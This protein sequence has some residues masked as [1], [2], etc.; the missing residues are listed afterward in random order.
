[1]LALA[2]IK[3]EFISSAFWAEALVPG[4]SKPC[5]KWQGNL[6]GQL[7]DTSEVC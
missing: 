5:H 6:D 1:M 3:G 7:K 2:K 4:I